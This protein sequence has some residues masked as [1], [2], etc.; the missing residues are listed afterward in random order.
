MGQSDRSLERY[1]DEADLRRIVL[2]VW[3]GRWWIVASMIF[4]GGL[5]IAYA[6]L[7]TPIFRAEA[8]VQIRQET[9]T[10]GD[11]NALAAQWAGL[12]DYSNVASDRALAIATL[13]SRVVIQAFIQEGNL[14]PEIFSSEWDSEHKRWNNSDPA[15][16]PTIWGGYKVFSDDI[17]RVVEDKKTGLVTVAIEWRDPNIAA[18]WTTELIARTNRYLRDAAVHDS[19]KS[20]EYLEGQIKQTGLVELQHAVY[21]LEETELKKLML[22]KGGDEYA[23]RTVDPAQAPRLRIRPKRVQITIL[24]LVLGGMIGVAIFSSVR[25]FGPKRTTSPSVQA[26]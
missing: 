3:Q 20:L 21:A 24:G 7:A 9:K 22:A 15:K 4:C 26:S 12:T 2:T 8:L 14:L 19:E 1:E 25:A 18:A 11:V 17:L 5:S 6:F 23:I 10:G 13:K 16:Q